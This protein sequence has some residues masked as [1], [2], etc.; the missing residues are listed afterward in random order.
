M[1]SL[2]P[3]GAKVSDLPERSS[4]W[5]HASRRGWEQ[6]RNAPARHCIPRPEAPPARN[7]AR[8]LQE[9]T[10]RSPRPQPSGAE[11]RGFLHPHSLPTAADPQVPGV[12]IRLGAA[13]P[14]DTHTHSR[15][16]L[17]HQAP[18]APAREPTDAPATPLSFGSGGPLRTRSPPGN[19]AAAARAQA[20][21]ASVA[22][23]STPPNPTPPQWSAF[24]NNLALF[25]HRRVNNGHRGTRLYFKR[26]ED[27][28]ADQLSEEL[29][30]CT[31][32]CCNAVN[33][34][35]RFFPILF[36]F[37]RLPSCSYTLPKL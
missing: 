7:P 28:K 4:L 16:L 25:E 34:L 30:R 18:E 33:S 36:A 6:S 19:P 37:F 21:S 31:G 20:H 17:L 2:L 27:Q 15:P 1:G 23:T 32:L 29:S 9:R 12:P 14:F 35:P 11:T 10:T 8:P 24:L 22:L 13:R 5:S 3:W 26:M